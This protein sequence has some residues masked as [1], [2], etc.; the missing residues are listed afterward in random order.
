[1]ALSVQMVKGANAGTQV[2]KKTVTISFSGTRGRM[3]A[4]IGSHA[5]IDAKA[6]SRRR[7]MVRTPRAILSD[8]E[9]KA[10]DVDANNGR[11]RFK[12]MAAYAEPTTTPGNMTRSGPV[13]AP[14]TFA[15]PNTAQATPSQRGHVL[16]QVT[17]MVKRPTETFGL[18]RASLRNT[19]PQF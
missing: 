16:S 10:W 2:R 6:K 18:D 8:D 9:A 12:P 13:R 3:M 1:Q 11:P 4:P 19:S 7:R 17:C 5:T 14:M 15:N